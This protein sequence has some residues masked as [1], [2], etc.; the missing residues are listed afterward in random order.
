MDVQLS[1]LF[2]IVSVQVADAVR[3]LHSI[4]VVHTDIKPRNVVLTQHDRRAILID[5]NGAEHVRA[6]NWRPRSQQYTTYPYRALE[7]WRTSDK[8]QPAARSVAPP[9]DIFGEKETGQRIL[10]LSSSSKALK[11][12]VATVSVVAASGGLDIREVLRH[13]LQPTPKSL[14]FIIFP[15][16]APAEGVIEY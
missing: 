12:L 14:A 5:F 8:A 11:S 4:G 16:V 15:P 6:E 1:V 3:F 13:A 10:S 2:C 7:L 9:I